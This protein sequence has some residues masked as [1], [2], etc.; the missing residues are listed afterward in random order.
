MT[1]NCGIMLNGKGEDFVMHLSTTTG[2]KIYSTTTAKRLSTSS[3]EAFAPNELLLLDKRQF[4]YC[5]KRNVNG[6]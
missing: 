2:I 3:R 1:E 5:E 4:S 6:I